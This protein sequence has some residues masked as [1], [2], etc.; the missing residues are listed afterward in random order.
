MGLTR[1]RYSSIQDTDYKQSVRVA[2]TEDVG[3][4]LA[5]GNMTNSVDGVTLSVNDRI[6]VKDQSD[7]KQNG[8]YF[9]VDAGTG[10]NG[11]WRRSLDADADFKVTSGMTTTIAEGTANSNKTFKLTTADPITLGTSN[12]TFVNPF[13]IT[14]T[15]GGANTQI[16]FHDTGSVISGSPGFTFNKFTN[17]VSVSGSITT[18][19]LVVNGNVSAAYYLGDGS[20][21]TGFDT[22]SIRNSTNSFVITHTNGNVTVKGNLVP[23]ANL[24]YNLGSPTQRWATGYFAGNTLDLGGSQIRVDNSSGTFTF[25]SNGITTN[26]GGTGGVFN[27]PKDASIGGNLVIA[28]DLFIAGNSTTFSTNNVVFNDALIYLA[29]GNSTDFLDIGF[30]GNFTRS[31]LNQFSGFVRDA[32]DGVWKLFQGVEPTPTTTIDFGSASYSTLLLG[33]VVT[34][35]NITVGTDIRLGRAL[36]SSAG[37]SGENGQY[38]TSTGLGIAWTTLD[39]STSSITDGATTTVYADT[40]VV[41]VEV[42]GSNVASVTSTGLLLSSGSLTFGNTG[43]IKIGINAGVTSQG[44]YTVAVGANAGNTSQQFG[45]VAIGYEAGRTSQGATAVAIGTDAGRDNQ[46]DEAVAVGIGAG[47]Y[48]QRDAAVAI[49]S[50]AGNNNQGISAVAI[51]ELAAT[52]N[53]GNA[54]IAV[55]VRAGYTSQ[56]DNSIVLNATGSNLNS[57]AASSFTVQPVRRTQSSGNLLAYSDSTGEITYSNVTVTSTGN[58]TVSGTMTATT[59]VET[60]S[61]TLKE[62]INPIT[63]ALGLIAQLQGVTYDRRDGSTHNEAGLIA[64]EVNRVLP[65]L[66]SLDDQGQPIGVYYTKLTAY[67]IE[68]VKSLKAEIDQLKGK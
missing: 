39:V 1:P 2:T 64:E 6:L 47:Q 20:Q 51:G 52:S 57:P 63:D 3:N 65:N 66:V 26:L 11:T 15:A 50:L 44:T 59:I 34:R 23:S 24:V 22:T 32:T 41:N 53:Q 36:L 7:S 60:S 5:T 12:L 56:H 68:A 8:I 13:V 25:I 40:G 49:G 27:T 42:G 43:Q 28:G 9:V 46:R 61:A 30:A 21:L 37:E 62:N 14:A 45:A 10:S 54:A 38:L 33:N 16:Q 29:N 4:L 19:N 31:S 55:G 48:N 67:L 58:L 18:A 17:T 35:G